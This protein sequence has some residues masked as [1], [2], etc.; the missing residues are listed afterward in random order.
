[1]PKTAMTVTR[2]SEMTAETG[3]VTETALAIEIETASEENV[4]KIAGEM[5]TKT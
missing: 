2:A 1:M 4:A 5:E 3:T